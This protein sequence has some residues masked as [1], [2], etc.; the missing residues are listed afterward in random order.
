MTKLLSTLFAIVMLARASTI[1][2]GSSVP[3]T[4]QSN[5]YPPALEVTVA[6]GIN[7]A[8]AAALGDSEWV[9]AEVDSTSIPNGTYITFGFSFDIPGLP[10]DATLGILTDDVGRGAI[11]G[12]ILFDDL[13]SGPAMYCATELPT[14]TVPLW[15]TIPSSDL[16]DGWNTLQVI[17]EQK[18][19]GP[20]GLDVY[21][22]VD[23][24]SDQTSPEPTTFLVALPLLALRLAKKRKYGET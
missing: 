8:W 22:T 7:P 2:F 13:S 23:Y 11:N 16:V 20:T 9:S 1:E 18:W 5:D 24:E 6:T 4:I 21:G 19:G 12:N 17:V 14:C 3:G 15:V 10:T